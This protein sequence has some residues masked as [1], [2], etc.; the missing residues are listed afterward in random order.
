MV[1]VAAA[2]DTVTLEAAPPNKQEVFLANPT[3]FSCGELTAVEKEPSDAVT[4]EH[5]ALNGV[6]IENIPV[7]P[8][9]NALMQVDVMA[10]YFIN[11]KYQC[12][13]IF[14]NVAPWLGEQPDRAVASF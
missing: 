3:G 12:H 13:N 4:V 5:K 1:I 14:H 11:P 7:E 2:H 10:G 8:K 6:A 9:H